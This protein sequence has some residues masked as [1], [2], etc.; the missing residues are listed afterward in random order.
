MYEYQILKLVLDY[1]DVYFSVISKYIYLSKTYQIELKYAFDTRVG[2][3]PVPV[4][5]PPLNICSSSFVT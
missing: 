1:K 3:N 4:L 2:H 5:A